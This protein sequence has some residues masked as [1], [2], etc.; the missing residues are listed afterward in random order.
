MKEKE[1]ENNHIQDKSSILVAFDN[2]EKKQSFLLKTKLRSEIRPTTLSRDMAPVSSFPKKESNSVKKK[3][4]RHK[5]SCISIGHEQSHITRI[6][7]LYQVLC[8]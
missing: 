1:K 8:L 6:Y 7:E 5:R 3:W 2:L 4:G